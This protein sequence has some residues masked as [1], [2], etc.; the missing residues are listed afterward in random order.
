MERVID[1]VLADLQREYAQ[2]SRG[3][4]HQQ[5][6]TLLR[7]YIAFFKVACLTGLHS[8][9]LGA[10]SP[11]D[12]HSLKRTGGLSAAMTVLVIALFQYGRVIRVFSTTDSMVPGALLLTALISQALTLYLPIG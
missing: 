3:P 4:R 9:R 2:V 1:P 11:E 8:L 7:G 10:W 12:R 5:L 6:R